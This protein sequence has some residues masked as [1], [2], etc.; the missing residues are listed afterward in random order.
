MIV[1]CLP[2]LAMQ[3]TI[4]VALA[5]IPALARPLRDVPAAPAQWRHA[6]ATA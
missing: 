3:R 4:F 6:L 2:P 5:A 1:F